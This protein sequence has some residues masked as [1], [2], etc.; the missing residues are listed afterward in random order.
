MDREL[1]LGGDE[2]ASDVLAAVAR[3][4]RPVVAAAARAAPPAVSFGR[5]DALRPG[6]EA[7]RAAAQRHGFAPV[8]RAPGGHAAAY[9]EGCLLV[10]EIVREPDSMPGVQER[11]ADRGALLVDALR[12]LGVDARARRGAARVLRRPPFRQRARRGE[13]GR[14]RPACRARRLAVRRG[15]HRHRRADRL[16]AVLTDVY[17]ALEIDL[18]PATVG[19]VAD[20]VPHTTVDDV[21]R[22][23]VAAYGM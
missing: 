21:R 10:E 8:L 13:A 17:A 12:S 16:R 22:A 19:A 2:A 20:E 1:D 7:A 14:H 4:E 23:V 3:G 9:H 5:L 6:Y 15:D 11:F 18:D